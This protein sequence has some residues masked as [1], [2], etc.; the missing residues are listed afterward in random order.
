MRM[1][2][3]DPKKLYRQHLLGEHVECHM[4]VGTILKGISL[5]GHIKK[6]LVE[7]HNLK[8]RYAGLTIEMISHGYNHNSPLPEFESFEGGKVNAIE[9]LQILKERCSECRERQ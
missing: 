1:W 6:G 5:E 8:V 7:V 2:Q 4:F 9:N 3:V